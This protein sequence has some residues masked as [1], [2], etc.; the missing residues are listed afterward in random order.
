MARPPEIGP[1]AGCLFAGLA[2]GAETGIEAI[3]VAGAPVAGLRVLWIVAC[4]RRRRL[5]GRR[6][7]RWR[8]EEPAGGRPWIAEHL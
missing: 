2:P 1:T 8:G 5:S 4:G 6:R 7:L 3:C